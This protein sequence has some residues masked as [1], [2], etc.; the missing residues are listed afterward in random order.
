MKM[1]KKM[2]YALEKI[3]DDLKEAQEF[4]LQDKTVLCRDFGSLAAMPEHKYTNGLGH[5]VHAVEKRAG[6]KIC[7]VYNAL[8]NIEQLLRKENTN[9]LT[10][11]N[12]I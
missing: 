8:R 10:E 11:R 4:I 3:R 5:V 2:R 6:S 1:N 9:L 7:Y 12:L